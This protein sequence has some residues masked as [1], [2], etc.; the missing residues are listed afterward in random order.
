MYFEIPGGD[1]YYFSYRN[2]ILQTISSN[3]GY[4]NEILN[5]K[6][7]RRVFKSKDEPFQYEF[8]ISSRR[9]MIDFKRRM[10]EIKGIST[11]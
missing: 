3:E 5:M 8:V 6:E 7:D 11:E 4:N 9:K 1:W 10:E 2:N